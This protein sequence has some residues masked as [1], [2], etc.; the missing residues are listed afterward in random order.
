M[1]SIIEIVLQLLYSSWA[2][3]SRWISLSK[4]W[5]ILQPHLFS[6]KVEV[7]LLSKIIFKEGVSFPHNN[8]KI[9]PICL[10]RPFAMGKNWTHRFLRPDT[11]FKL[12]CYHILQRFLRLLNPFQVMGNILVCLCHWDWNWRQIRQKEDKLDAFMWIFW[13]NFNFIHRDNHS[14]ASGMALGV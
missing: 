13:K 12:A 10:Y 9:L 1:V 5:E 3:W 7:N 6:Q 2:S 14:A 8:K 4:V 11:L